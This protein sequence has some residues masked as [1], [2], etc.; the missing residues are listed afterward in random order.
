MRNL[1]AFAALAAAAPAAPALAQTSQDEQVWVNVTLM[2]SAKDDLLYF[3][4]AQPRLMEGLSEMRQALLRGA[5][6]WKLNDRLSIYQGYAYVAQPVEGAAPDRDEHRSFQQVSWTLLPGAT[7]LSSRTRFEQ[8]WITG[9]DDTG[10]R[11]RQMVRLETPLA[12]G[13]KPLKALFSVEGMVAFNDTDWGARS[14]FDQVRSFAG[15][16]VPLKGK[17]TVE[18]G[19]LNQFVNRPGNANAVNHVASVSLFIRP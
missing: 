19:Y 11:L 8:R 14:G 2:G 13:A 3:V 4:E 7:E 10:W 18:A 5:I 17:T 12:A 15:F 9:F 6:G 1:I 16:E